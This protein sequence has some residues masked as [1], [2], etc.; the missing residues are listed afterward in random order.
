M[1]W[2]RFARVGV[3]LG[4]LLAGVALTGCQPGSPDGPERPAPAPAKLPASKVSIQSLID[5]AKDGQAVHVPRARYVSRK[6]VL[7]KG[8]K[9]LR[10][11]CEKGTQ[12]LVTHTYECVLSVVESQDVRIENAFL[13]H[14]KPREEYACHGSVVRISDSKS[15]SVFN[16]DLN[17][18]GAIGVAAND[19]RDITVKNC[20]I[21]HNTFNAF[22]F[23]GCEHIRVLGNIIEDNANLF[24]MYR[25][26]D[27]E[28]RDNV[29]RRNG[30]YW[31]DRDPNPGLKK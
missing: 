5:A 13:S 23:Q 12:I 24:Q 17:G 15:V 30:S 14:V 10:I 29:V 1:T 8:R 9:G 28:W 7:I 16:C 21:H 2:M 20:L 25:V 27:V 11:V 4:I 26:N 6:A 3:T 31:D 18:C 22:Y 19:S